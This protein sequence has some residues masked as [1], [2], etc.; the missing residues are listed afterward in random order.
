M[1]ADV[2]NSFA[3]FLNFHPTAPSLVV[4]VVPGLQ[5]G[6]ND[7]NIPNPHSSILLLLLSACNCNRQAMNDDM[8]TAI[9]WIISLILDIH[10]VR[11][12]PSKQVWG[13]YS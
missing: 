5:L 8:S 13:A 10:C 11:I 6:V 2:P 12:W 4:M 7:E 1:M 3:A 9:Q